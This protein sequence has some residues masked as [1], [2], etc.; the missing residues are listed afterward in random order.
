MKT[1]HAISKEKKYGHTHTQHTSNHNKRIIKR[2]E[3]QKELVWQRNHNCSLKTALSIRD[4]YVCVCVFVYGNYTHTNLR[5]LIIVIFGSVWLGSVRF[6]SNRIFNTEFP[7]SIFHY[8]LYCR[9]LSSFQHLFLLPAPAS[10]LQSVFPVVLVD[11]VTFHEEKGVKE[12]ERD[13]KSLHKFASVSQLVK[14]TS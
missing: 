3:K 10:S 5:W 9:C 12:R 14:Q 4:E 8:C 13:A 1:Q 7:F 2:R 11:D 6:D